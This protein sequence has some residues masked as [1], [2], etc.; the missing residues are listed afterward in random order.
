MNILP[1]SLKLTYEP[2]PDPEPKIKEIISESGSVIEIVDKDTGESNPNF[3]YDDIP[4]EPLDKEPDLPTFVPKPQPVTSMFEEPTYKSEVKLTKKGRPRKPMS[5]SHKAKLAIAREKANAKKRYLKEQRD[6]AKLDALDKKKEIKQSDVVPQIKV[7]AEPAPQP[8]PEPEPPK[9]IRQSNGITI[10]DLEKAQLNTILTIEKM[11]KD[12]KTEKKKKQLEEEY[13]QE[14]IK[15][16]KKI[17]NWQQ[18]A[19]QYANCF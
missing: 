7:V 15:T 18:T 9:S 14:T 10:E 8:T 19:G 2:E 5:D 3:V 13:K 17:N 16:I 11:R 1:D 12:R 4:L 6:K